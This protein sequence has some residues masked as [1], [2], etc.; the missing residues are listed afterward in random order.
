[1]L[2][3]RV[4]MTAYLM[5]FA[6]LFTRPMWRRVPFL[7]AKALLASSRR[8]VALPRATGHRDDDALAPF[9]RDLNRAVWSCP[10]VSRILLGLLS[11]AVAPAGRSA[12]H[13]R[14]ARTSARPR[15]PR[16][17]RPR[18]GL[19]SYRHVDTALSLGAPLFTRLGHQHQCNDQGD[20]IH[21]S[22]SCPRVGHALGQL[23]R[24]TWRR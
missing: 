23:V 6:P 14:D 3:Q 5:P 11:A 12:G 2:I 16:R 18:S 9:R 10:G 13:R 19:S 24:T 8:M 20:E 21:R 15:D 17:P 22:A 1:M 4:A 7:V